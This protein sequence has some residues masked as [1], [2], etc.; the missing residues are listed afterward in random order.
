MIKSS[1]CAGCARVCEK[2]GLFMRARPS[3]REWFFA[4]KHAQNIRIPYARSTPLFGTFESLCLL[5]F[6]TL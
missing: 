2:V 3:S 1:A 5:D 6:R 4:S